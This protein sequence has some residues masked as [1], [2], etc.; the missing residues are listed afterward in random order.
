MLSIGQKLK[1]SEYTEEIVTELNEKQWYCKDISDGEYV[2]EVAEFP[3]F[4]F[5]YI[6]SISKSVNVVMKAYFKANAATLNLTTDEKLQASGLC[7][8]W[9]AGKHTVGEIVN[10]GSQ[11]WECTQAHDNATYPDIN[12]DKSQTWANFWK[13]LHGT[14]PKTA[15][16]WTKPVAGTTDM[17]LVG[18]YAIFD[19]VVAKAKRN[20][21]YSLLEYP[22]DWEIISQ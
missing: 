22:D 12:P 14:T 11:T 7:D 18:E 17:Y 9:T 6:P 5:E 4:Q 20:T 10:V 2:Y 15:R 19:N 21:V 8:T 13:P 16:P 1:A 3:K